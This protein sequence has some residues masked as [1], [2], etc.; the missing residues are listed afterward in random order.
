MKPIYLELQAFGP[1]ADRQCVDFEKLSQGGIFLI[2]GETGSGKTTIFDAMTFAL[3]GGASGTDSTGKTGRNDLE[4]WRCTQADARTD[5]L[6]SFTFSVRGRTYNFTR[7]LVKAT[8]NFNPHYGAGEVTEDGVLVPFFNNPKQKDLNAK[9]EELL[10]LTKEQFRQVVLLPQGQ[11]ERFLTA[12]SEEKEKILQTIFGTCR[13][14]RYAKCFFDEAYSRKSALDSEKNTVMISLADDG[15]ASLEELQERISQLI[16]Q[17]QVTEAAHLAFDG[18]RRQNELNADILLYE[19]FKLLHTLE[20]KKAALEAKAEEIEKKKTAYAE[21]ESAE[22]LRGCIDEFEKSEKELA[23]R[24]KELTSLNEAL[25]EKE[26]ALSAAYDAKRLCDADSPVPELQKRLGEYESKRPVLE[27]FSLLSRSYISAE[28]AFEEADKSLSSAKAALDAVTEETAECYRLYSTCDNTASEAR[29]RYY[30]GIYGELA[31]DLH[32]GEKCPVCGSIHHP[33][34]A[35]KAPDSVS[36]EELDRC[37]K[38]A[39]D[40]KKAWENA[41]QRRVAAD[42]CARLAEAKAN[43]LQLAKNAAFIKLEEA[44]KA[45]PQGLLSVSAL[46]NAIKKCEDGIRAHEARVQKLDAEIESSKA[47][48]ES[49]KARISSASHELSLAREKHKECR[50]VLSK[51]LAENGYSDYLEVKARL[52]DASTRRALHAEIVEYGTACLDTENSLKSKQEELKGCSEPDST[53]FNS[54]QAEIKAESEEYSRLAGT[55]GASIERLTQKQRDLSKVMEHYLSNIHR[56]ESDLAFAKKL[57]GDSSIGLQRYVLAIMFNQVI[58][59]ANQMLQSVHGGRYRL[60]RTDDKASGNKRGLE[61]KVFDSRSPENEKG[62]SVSMLSG[63]EKF[64]VSLA[65]SIGL[66]TVAQK[67]GVQID[68]LFIDEGFGTLDFSSIDDALTVLDGVRRGSG[69]IGIISHVSLL[70]STIPTKLEVIKSH[71]G[72]S[73]RPA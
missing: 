55:L 19:Q 34:P 70:E 52:T 5:T 14:E 67:S 65:L 42:N 49:L 9:A 45:L 48:C 37:E 54:R 60:F 28:A 43:S 41:E 73:I 44:K 66:S 64:L 7:S 16:E 38:R 50:A 53:K 33:E 30:S 23:R 17:R 6:V 57:R 8:K 46:N 36:K 61:L 10:G 32:E 13:W 63:G 58:G 68:A 11:F 24:E 3:Y 71:S 62:R 47:A 56:A 39:A 40:K 72:S 29:Q 12:S 26:I 35:L 18:V 22:A 25:P 31:A 59:E 21:A 27:S 15:L 51:A 69:T 1:F 2:K 20:Q 4:E